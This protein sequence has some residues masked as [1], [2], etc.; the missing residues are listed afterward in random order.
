[1]ST[2]F[3]YIYLNSDSVKYLCI[4]FTEKNPLNAYIGPSQ[5][6]LPHERIYT[7]FEPSPDASK[8]FSL[9]LFEGEHPSAQLSAQILHTTTFVSSLMPTKRFS[10]TL[11]EG[12]HSS[13]QLSAQILHTT[14][15]VSS[16]MPQNDFR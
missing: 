7:T 11:F 14:T 9:T 6:L 4:R 16:L 13:A 10:L 5:Y 15:F 1:M 2:I 12:E 8:R 3:H